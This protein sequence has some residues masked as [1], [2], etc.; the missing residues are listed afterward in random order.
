M[1]RSLYHTEF[2][3][4]LE[5]DDTTIGSPGSDRGLG[6]ESPQL[7]DESGVDSA[8]ED[9]AAVKIRCMYVRQL[10]RGQGP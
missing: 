1:R 7:D 10:R 6:N 5:D 8:E 2:V 9:L 3:V 4:E